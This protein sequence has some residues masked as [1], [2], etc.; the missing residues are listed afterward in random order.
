MTVEE[1]LDVSCRRL[2]KRFADVIVVDDVDLDIRS[3]EFFS[4]LGPS[5]CGKTTTLRMLAGLEH[6]SSGTI[7]LGGQDITQVPAH[8][9][10]TN[11][12]FQQGALFPHLT[13][14]ENVEFG[15]RAERLD[16]AEAR[17]RAGEML[18]LVGLAHL[19][20]RR[21]AQLSGGQAQR[22]AI[23]RAL[24]KR[25][26]VLLLDEPL[27]AL[28]LKLQVHMRRELKNLQRELGTTFVCVTHNQTEAL[29]MSDRLAVMNG[30]RIEQVG[31]GPEIYLRPASRFVASFIGETNFVEGRV[32]RGT[33]DRVILDAGGFVVEARHGDVAAE[34]GGRASV[35]VRPESIELH[36]EGR[37]GPNNAR[38][39][40]ADLLYLGNTMRYVVELDGGPGVTVDTRPTLRP[41]A[42]GT[43]V[44]ASW[45]VDAAV[46]LPAGQEP[47]DDH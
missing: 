31:T 19:R 40:V 5:G 36:T 44:T 10:A 34:P 42:A 23:A 14:A 21:P 30:G 11:L 33:G 28:D 39:T 12:V 16:R 20:D 13:V 18:E 7:L 2:C 47:P 25:P 9:R 37:T 17:K 35:M 29:E 22:I 41:I 27:S 32:M 8:R 15:L 43:P 1:R 3:G 24:V 26:P 46:L 38:G 45:P 4:L 6:P